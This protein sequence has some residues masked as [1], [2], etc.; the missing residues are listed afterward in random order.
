M[1][2]PFSNAQ[3]QIEKTAEKLNLDKNVVETLKEPMR[4]LQ[5]RIPIK[6]DDGSIKTFTGFRVQYN[7][8]RGPTKGGIRYHPNES[9]DTVKALAAWMTWK[10]AIADIPFGGAKGGIICNPKEMS[11]AEL[12]R[13]SR[14]YIRQIAEFI[15]PDKD[16]PAPDVYTNPQTMAW[17]LDEYEKI[18]RKNSPAVITGKPLEVGGSKGRT[19]ATGFGVAINIR[20][21]AKKIGL[22]L[23]SAKVA[24]QGFGNVGMYVAKSLEQMGA[25]IIALSDSKGGIYNPDGISVEKA[26]K[27]KQEIG[28]LKGLEGT[29]EISNEELLELECDILIPAALENQITKDNAD[30]IKAKIIAEA[31]NGPTT[32]EADEILYKNGKFLIPD[33]LCNAGGV[34]VSYFEWVQNRTGDYW[35][36]EEV[37]KRLDEKLTSAFSQ[38]VKMAEK[39]KVDN[40]T[41]AYMIAMKRV[42]DA[43]KLKGII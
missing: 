38:M 29:K 14:G 18:V 9:L 19:K 42:V 8:A 2:N 33:I 10:C 41:A 40:R 31:A 43:M 34:I 15:G 11:Q 23:N 39:E 30:K 7:N 1:E 3:K 24:I 22:E 28:S 13:L 21:A 32:P 6:M 5:V 17:M 4:I 36:E 20:E 26:I 35:S 37:D 16:I 12:E 27:H 25:K